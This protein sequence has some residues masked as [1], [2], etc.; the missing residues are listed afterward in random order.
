MVVWYKCQL[1]DSDGCGY[2][3]ECPCLLEIHITVFGEDGE[4]S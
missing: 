2:V 1:P 3:D 4:S